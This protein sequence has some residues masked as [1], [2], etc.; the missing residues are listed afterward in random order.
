M[1]RCREMKTIE[2]TGHD[3]A[4]DEVADKGRFPVRA[5]ARSID[6]LMALTAGPR[7]LGA[8]AKETRLS[9]ATAHRLLVTLAYQDLVIQD[10]QAGEYSLGPGCFRLVEAVSDGLSGLSAV[11]RP[12]LEALRDRTGETV[13]LHVRIASQRICIQELASR[14][15]M[16]YMAGLG[17][18]APIHVGSAGK[19]L[20]A[21]LD[22]TE[23]EKLLRSITLTPV[24]GATITDPDALRREF[25][26]IR[27][28]GWAESRGERIVGAASLSTPVFDA[29]GAIVAALSVL[30]PEARFD[31]ARFAEARDLAIKAAA[32]ATEL[33]AAHGWTPVED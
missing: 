25:E 30:G 20:L 22:P 21:Y 17:A 12:I 16:R 18:T 7:S 13:T 5:V 19:L 1:E 15:E 2:G 4:D 26:R 9:K 10:P 28:R 23:R 29:R 11:T 14:H 24:T 31:K 3:L 32:E 6:L 33:L 27:R 8:L